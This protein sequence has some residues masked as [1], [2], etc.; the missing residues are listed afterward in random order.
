MS[1]KADILFYEL[2]PDAL[3]NFQIR[4]YFFFVMLCVLMALKCGGLLGKARRAGQVM[5][6]AMPVLLNSPW[7]TAL[8]NI[9]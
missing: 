9:A 4:H 8:L 6:S 3:F 2:Q 7:F 1:G 5:Q